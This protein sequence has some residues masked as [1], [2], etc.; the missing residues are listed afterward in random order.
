MHHFDQGERERLS[1]AI[2]IAAIH[3]AVGYLVMSQSLVV[4]IPPAREGLSVFDVKSIPEP[5]PEPEKAIPKRAPKRE[6]AAAPPNRK[7]RPSPVVAPPPVVRTEIPPPVTA[8]PI[9]AEGPDATAG[10]AEVEGPGTGSG[11]EGVGTGSGRYGT[12]TGGGGGTRALWMKGRI[13][14]SDYPR[15]ASRAKVGGTVTVRFDIGTDGYV[16]N[17]RVTGSS[18]NADLDDTTCRLIEKRFR[19]KP[20]TDAEGRPVEDVGAWRQFWWLEP[21]D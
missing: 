3:L 4:V 20:A 5:K 14:D 17:C 9:P 8:A 16:S 21:N 18:G 12:G 7:S 13:K 10:A 6:G 15:A 19:Y 2:A 1:I 11:G